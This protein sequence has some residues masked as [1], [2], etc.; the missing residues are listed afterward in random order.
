MEEYCLKLLREK[1]M[2]SMPAPD[3]RH[4]R[5]AIAAFEGKTI[6]EIRAE[7]PRTSIKMIAES[8]RSTRDAIRRGQA[9]ELVKEQFPQLVQD[10]KAY[11]SGNG[12]S[13][14][15]TAIGRALT[16]ITTGFQGV[17]AMNFRE[18]IEDVR[19]RFSTIGVPL[20]MQKIIEGVE[21]GDP[22]MIKLST[23]VFHLTPKKGGINLGFNLA[24]GAGDPDP[25]RS[26]N[27]ERRATFFED[28]VRR[29]RAA[30]DGSDSA[31]AVEV[32]EVPEDGDDDDE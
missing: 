26:L 5:I 2:P 28:I 10:Q 1:D 25:K 6:G 31:A 15:P 21:G 9:P 29:K 8:I 3:D 30:I 32:I 23:E 17:S 12:G 24:P 4:I 22:T 7:Y 18:F 20:T 14:R 19:G 11:K 16:A 13:T 27:P